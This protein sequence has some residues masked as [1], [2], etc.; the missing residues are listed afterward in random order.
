M[1][2]KNHATTVE[3]YAGA[4]WEVT[5]S[6]HVIQHFNM[7]IMTDCGITPWVSSLPQIPPDIDFAILTHP[8]VD[9]IGGLLHFW[10]KNKCPVFVPQGAKQ[11][12]KTALWWTYNIQSR[13][14]E[15][16]NRYAVNRQWLQNV[17]ESLNEFI[18]QLQEESQTPH[19]RMNRSGRKDETLP[20][21]LRKQLLDVEER[22]LSWRISAN[23]IY[24]EN[25]LWLE[26]YDLENI[27]HIKL[28]G[29]TV[30]MVWTPPK[31]RKKIHDA[32]KVYRKDVLTEIINLSYRSRMMRLAEEEIIT[33][34][35]VDNCIE[36]IRELT[37]GKY[38]KIFSGKEWDEVDHRKSI[39]VRFQNSGHLYSATSAQT[40]YRLG[41][42]WGKHILATGDL[43]NDKQPHPYPKIDRQNLHEVADLVITEGTYGD[44]NHADREKELERFERILVD[45]IKKGDDI[46]IPI[47]SLDRPIFAMW[48]IVTR[49]LEKKSKIGKEANLKPSDFECL[50]LWNDLENFLPKG[51]EIWRKIWRHFKY[52]EPE[53]IHN[54][55]KKWKKTRIIFAGGGFLPPR[56]P[57]AGVLIYALKRPSTQVIFMNYCGADDSNARR[58]LTG[59]PFDAYERVKNVETRHVLEL[60]RDRGHI[61]GWLSGHADQETIVDHVIDTCKQ[62]TTVIINHASEDGR[63]SLRKALLSRSSHQVNVILPQHKKTYVV[64]K[65]PTK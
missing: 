33:P 48:E 49:L 10:M 1:N 9:H 36:N 43:G 53:R 45:A 59:L 57:A 42:K 58:L 60:P 4:W 31:N 54:L 35:D 52:L 2:S 8:H 27:E 55:A 50:Y 62:G 16:T 51:T 46:V 65:V 34:E 26:G 15:M 39:E 21:A 23:K 19:R 24:L 3:F 28:L 25:M 64:K 37:L 5:P 44:R 56:S 30:G 32:E 47:I 41:G 11:A 63:N 20:H 6:C 12:I 18:Y 29:E 22:E 7:R 61:I 40:L 13:Q 17:K 14:G 38:H